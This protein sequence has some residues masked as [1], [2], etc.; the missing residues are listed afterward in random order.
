MAEQVIAYKGLNGRLYVTEKAAEYSLN[1]GALQHYGMHLGE[2][3]KSRQNRYAE[4]FDMALLACVDD[5]RRWLAAY[6]RVYPKN[7]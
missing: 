7:G 1:E 6:D 5:V 3:I 4:T 2:Y